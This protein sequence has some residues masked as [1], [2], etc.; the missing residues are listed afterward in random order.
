MSRRAAWLC[1][2]ASSAAYTTRRPDAD[3]L[4]RT[5]TTL[6]APKA[7][8]VYDDINNVFTDNPDGWAV[9]DNSD[10]SPT[11]RRESDK[12]S[13]APVKPKCHRCGTGKKGE[14]NCCS[15]GGAWNG[16]CTASLTEGGAHTFV[17]GFEACVPPTPE[18][19]EAARRKASK[20]AAA[21]VAG[22][23]QAAAHGEPDWGAHSG[24]GAG[25][26]EDSE[27]GAIPLATRARK[28]DSEREEWCDGDPNAPASAFPAGGDAALCKAT[29]DA[30]GNSKV[31]DSWCVENCGF[32]PPNCPLSLCECDEFAEEATPE[33][34]AK[35]S[36][37]A[38]DA[39][40][41][42]D[43]A[44]GAFDRRRNSGG[45]NE[46]GSSNVDEA[47]E[48]GKEEY[49]RLRRASTGRGVP[50][51][52]GSNAQG[53]SGLS[54]GQVSTEPER[55]SGG[56]EAPMRKCQSEWDGN[57][58]RSAFTGKAGAARAKRVAAAK[59]KAS[60]EELT[61]EEE[62]WLAEGA[63]DEQEENEE[64]VDVSKLGNDSGLE[65]GANPE[66]CV[67]VG[68]AVSDGWCKTACAG[69]P[70]NCPADLC[71]CE[72][73]VRIKEGG[74]EEGETSDVPGVGGFTIDATCGP[75]IGIKCGQ[76]VISSGYKADEI[77]EKPLL[78][79]E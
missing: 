27:D 54:P 12:K 71:S 41:K 43:W 22:G 24:R 20:A 61:K 69:S 28:C 49:N 40:A 18:E 15:P 52:T 1:A 45:A 31:D 16:A 55:L 77:H 50:Q 13:E 59:R 10:N 62:G 67:T 57:C 2:L 72:K 78:A 14:L 23:D 8:D 65:D 39:D 29:T 79:R 34:P 35:A 4:P 51:A 42:G 26:L 70:P 46:D 48:R 58:D 76:K 30:R 7:P 63:A 44:K 3:R 38:R 68:G 53:S 74:A 6:V 33:D 47:F 60:G 25:G 75:K 9:K 36:A 11:K 64:K 19:E 17:E 37:A 73:V 21:A 5:A 32:N 66:D 56:Y